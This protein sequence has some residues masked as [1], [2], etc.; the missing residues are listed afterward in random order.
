M[1]KP[2]SVAF[3][4]DYY[5]GWMGG[6][7]LLGFVFQCAQLAAAAQNVR[8]HLLLS[9]AMLPPPARHGIDGFLPLAPRQIAADGPLRALLDSARPELVIFYADLGRTLDLLGVDV[10]GPT[11][12]DLST[13]AAGRPWFA[14][15]PDF[16]HQYLPR[17]FSQEER[18]AR[19]RQFRL[20]VENAAGVFVN[21]ATVAS[22]IERFYPGS[23]RRARILRLPQLLP[24]T[25]HH[26]ERG[27]EGVLERYGIR[28]PYLLSCSQRW[29]HK[30][31]DLIVEAFA[32]IAQRCPQLELV[33]T[34]ERT[35]HRD[36]EYAARVQAAIQRH[37][38]QGRVHSVG[39]IPRDEQLALIADAQ[40]IVQASIF[41]G[42]P[43]ASGTL[44][45]AL[46]GTPIVA[47]DIPANR[48]LMFAAAR[49]FEADSIDGLVRAIEGALEG[50]GDGRAPPFTQ[51]ERE[52]LAM[53]SGL[54]F[55]AALRAVANS[56]QAG[57]K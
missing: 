5:C 3:L 54:A 14:Y 18:L 46:L 52:V 55:L 20:L 51:D 34:G 16:Q 1:H 53:A 44:E 32:R 29:L 2:L 31:H 17:F 9:A 23:S 4:A 24:A 8:L 41:E 6:A 39:L 12:F 25:D 38:L 36:P 28:R 47:S 49:F 40:A 42:G 13:V 48:E 19:D 27:I 43:G 35:D 10:I 33:F 21:S 7:N 22:D 45:A 26:C 15:I 56:A 30:R 50:A 37:G 11:G 57:S